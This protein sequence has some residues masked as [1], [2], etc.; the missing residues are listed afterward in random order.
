MRID[1]KETAQ[2]LLAQ[3][4]IVILCH[5]NPDG[6]T[7]GSGCGL[8][9]ALKQ[10]GKRS[11]VLC[12]DAVPH[13][14]EYLKSEEVTEAFPPRFIVAVDIADEQLFGDALSP[15]LGKVD[16]AID[17]H[18]SNSMFAKDTLLDPGA[19]ATCEIMYHLLLEMGITVTR[20]IADCLYTGIATDTGCFKFA[21]VTPDTH[22]IAASLIED[23]CRFQKINKLLFESKTPGMLELE[24][25]VLN[26]LEFHGDG[27][28][29]FITVTRD[30]LRE[31]GVSEAELDGI[32]GIPRKIE[33]VEVGV[34][35]KEHAQNEYK[36]SVRSSEL[37]DASKFCARFGGGGHARAAGCTICGTLD[38]VRSRIRSAL[39]QEL[40]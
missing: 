22:R 20:Q 29:A 6:D 39:K 38:E 9:Y 21:N 7:L 27:R 32:S 12:S 28:I 30:M 4:D 16:L 11:R 26:T 35:I 8:H 40:M 5:R 13:K 33:G 23:G 1:R 24:R 2:R 15:Y 14:M 37:L 19:A 18:P 17:H 36:L 10:L 25:Q 34:T 31:T 3:D